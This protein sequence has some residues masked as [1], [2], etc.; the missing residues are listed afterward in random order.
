M[1]RIL[2]LLDNN[3]T[4]AAVIKAGVDWSSAFERG[5]PTETAAKFIKLGLRPSIVKLLTSYMTSRKMSIKF[6]G[7]ESSLIDLCGGFPAGSVIGQDC[8]LVASNSSAD[9]VS[10]DDRFKY[11]DDLEI[12]EL[13]LLSGILEHFDTLASVPSYLP[14]DHKFLPGTLTQTQSNLD[15][16]ARWTSNN[17][18]LLNPAKWCL[19]EARSSL[20]PG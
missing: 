3:S 20:L 5:D 6:N 14:F 13:V 16:I 10:E 2:Y 12:L 19:A 11:I 8:Y 18:M 9:D 15:S 1:D 7:Q 17:K 4:R